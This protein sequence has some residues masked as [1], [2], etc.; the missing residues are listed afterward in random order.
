MKYDFKSII[1]S[2]KK[3]NYAVFENNTRPYNLNI[4]GIRA[5]DQIVNHFNDT[6]AVFYF[7]DNQCIYQEY[8]VTT[9]PGSYFLEKPMNINGC[10]IVKE[11]QYPNMWAIGKHYT[12][13][14]LVQISPCTVIRDDNKDDILD[15]NTGKEETGIF[16]IDCHRKEAPGISTTIDQASAGCTVLADHDRFDNQFMPLM[17]EASKIYGNQFTYT[18]INEND[19][20]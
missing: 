18:L 13:T 4:V 19:I 11:G 1:N 9:V 3:K 10:A 17:Q 20:V 14:A 2:M 12:Q 6:L 16:A 5:K 7:Y 15:F 8:I